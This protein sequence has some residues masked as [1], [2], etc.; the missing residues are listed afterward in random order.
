[1]D[2]RHHFEMTIAPHLDAGYNL[3]C[4]VLRDEFA[5]RD[6]M[7][8]A[9]LQAFRFLHTCRGDSAKA[10]FFSI[11]RNACID[12]FR[13]TKRESLFVDIDDEVVLQ[14]VDIQ[15]VSTHSPEHLLLNQCSRQQIDAAIAALPAAY[16]EVIV[17]REMEEM[18]YQDI[19]QVTGIPTGTVMSR[20]S[21]AREM[22]R[23]E[24]ASML[25]DQ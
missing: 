19:A 8:N 4:R 7:Q 12:H 22:L 11:V 9:A 6:V 13:V 18:S 10:W 5:A 15:H 23:N 24:L 2:K 17:L 21:R 1:M 20:L 16:R 25:E 3:A 14:Q